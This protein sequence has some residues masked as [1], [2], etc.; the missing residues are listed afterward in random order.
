M[1]EWRCLLGTPFEPF[2]VLV[3]AMRDAVLE[4]V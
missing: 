1:R 2:A 3:F 4:D